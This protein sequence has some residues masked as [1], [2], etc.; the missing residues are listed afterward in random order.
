MNVLLLIIKLYA[1]VSSRS[2]SVIA[3]AVDSVLDL[4]SG[5]ILFVTARAIRNRDPMVYPVG[6]RRLEPLGI[7]VFAAVMG[8]AALQLITTS[9][10]ALAKRSTSLNVQVSTIVILLVTI[11]VKLLLYVWCRCV[12]RKSAIVNALATDHI[13]DVMVNGVGTACAVIAKYYLW[14]TDALGAILLALW[15]IRTWFSTGYEQLLMLAGHT[16]PNEFLNK[17]SFLAHLHHEQAEVDTVR[18]YYFGLY[19]MV[20]VDIKL[21]EDMPLRTA[22][23]IGEALAI[24]IEEFDEVER[25]FVHIDFETT[26][27]PEHKVL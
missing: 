24:R 27:K 6:R 2:L 17:I 7:I 4:V 21:P 5:G 14:W 23:D 20:E 25:A 8:T 19:F 18:A 16:A 13:T 1:A 9:I 3:S 10:E 12:G 26:H 11:T 15:I 22:H